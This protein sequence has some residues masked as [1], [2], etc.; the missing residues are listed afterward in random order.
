MASTIDE[1]E[2]ARRMGA[3]VADVVHWIEFGQLMA[4]PD[5]DGWAV[6][7]RDFEVFEGAKRLGRDIVAAH[8]AHPDLKWR[9][10]NCAG[11][12]KLMNQP[13]VPHE[14]WVCSEACLASAPEGAEVVPAY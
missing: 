13:T 5:G 4:V 11:C 12:G 14:T 6:D 10:G 8:Q 2:V 1:H 9:R 3:D 7:L